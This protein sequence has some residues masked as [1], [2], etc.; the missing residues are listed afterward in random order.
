MLTNTKRSM[1]LLFCFCVMLTSCMPLDSRRQSIYW[2]NEEI[3][4]EGD[5]FTYKQ[6]RASDDTLQ[7]VNFSG[8]DTIIRV[9]LPEEESV[10]FNIT[11]FVTK[12]DFKCVLIT[13]A[14]QIFLLS[15]QEVISNF[16]IVLPAGESRIKVV[17]HRA[18][19]EFSREL[20]RSN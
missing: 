5:T 17:G 11:S 2:N 13:P 1:L 10:E 15:E 19:G 20:V 7:Y 14:N 6:H 16:T 3:V 4:K 12:G 18:T 9:N 8:T